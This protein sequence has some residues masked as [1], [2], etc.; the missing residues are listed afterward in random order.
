ML[1]LQSLVNNPK[2]EVVDGKYAFKPKYNLKDKKAL[3]RLLDKHDQRGLGG[4]LL[5]DIEEGLPNA[6]KAIKVSGAPA[7]QRARLL[8]SSNGRQRLEEKFLLSFSCS[9][10]SS[11]AVSEGL[12]L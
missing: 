10:E 3:L 11:T 12:M 9:C 8:S 2:I 5:E 7:I 4:I 6:Q 1:L